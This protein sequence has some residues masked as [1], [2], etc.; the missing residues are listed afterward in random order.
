MRILEKSCLEKALS[1]LRKTLQRRLI[2]VACLLLLSHQ[3][4]LASTEDF[5]VETSLKKLSYEERFYLKTFFCSFLKNE[6]LG[7]VL[8]GNTKPASFCAIDK[9]SHRKSF[10]Q[11]LLLKGWEC[12]KRSEE[13]FPHPNFVFIEEEVSFGDEEVLH[14]FVINEKTLIAAL[15]KNTE[16]FKEV[17]GQEFTPESFLVS[18]QK[19][20]CLRPLLNHDEALFGIVLGF[21]AESSVAYKERH[22][23]IDMG[24]REWTAP[25]WTSNYKGVEARC[26]KKCRLHPVGF[27]GNPD[28]AEVKGLLERYTQE[29]DAISETYGRSKNPLIF[30]LQKLSEND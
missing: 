24:D 17:L 23:H 22:K 16:L 30:V 29:L 4:L 13:L 5:S 3:S 11:K 8:L 15:Q 14:I 6:D 10:Y 21:G 27:V 20:Q 1:Q 12:W 9:K 2:L 26:G 7:H 28:S 25:E 18:M 19:E